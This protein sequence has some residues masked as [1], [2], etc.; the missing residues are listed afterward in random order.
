M[1]VQYLCKNHWA[2]GLE[3]GLKRWELQR[4]WSS[5]SFV[6][7][8]LGR[9]WSGSNSMPNVLD[10]SKYW[11]A[12]SR[13]LFCDIFVFLTNWFACFLWLIWTSLNLTPYKEF[14]QIAAKI[15]RKLP[16]VS[17][18]SRRQRWQPN[19]CPLNWCLKILMWR[20]VANTLL[21]QVFRLMFKFNWN[22]QMGS[23]S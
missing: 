23:V 4:L 18:L 20:S 1:E 2:L 19:P 14:L 17:L 6:G 21:H 12:A 3:R 7:A 13:T 5:K 16:F 10:N 15:S 8:E 9:L 11:S 22:N